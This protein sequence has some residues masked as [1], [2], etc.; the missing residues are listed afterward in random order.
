MINIKKVEVKQVNTKSK[1]P[2]SDYVINPYVGCPHGCIYCYAEFMKRFTGHGDEWGSFLD[3]KCC[4]KKINLKPMTNKTILLSSVTD[5]YNVYEGKYKVTRGILEQLVDVDARVEILTKSSLVLRDIDLFKKFK[6][7]HIGISLNTLDDEFR[8]KIEP[9]ASSVEQRVKAIK[10]LKEE[11][12]KTYLFMSPM[13]PEITNYS[14]IIDF[15]GDD[16]DYYCFENLNLRGKYKKRVLDFIVEYKPELKE[17]YD[18]I[19]ISGRNTYWNCIEENIVKKC[20]KDN[21]AYKIYFY[22][23]KIKKK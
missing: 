21:L 19:Y 23:D 12:I 4:G 18:D 3:I 9:R 13:F 5:A 11:K 20:K 1:L 14:E 10:K 8:R 22:H 6:D 2:D 17:I 15:I 16:V 7:I